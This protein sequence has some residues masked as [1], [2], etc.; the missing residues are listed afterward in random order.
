M[1]VQPGP[2]EKRY[3]ANGVTTI[4][5]VPFLV[6]EPGDLQVLLNGVLLS[7][8]YTHTGVGSPTSTITFAVAPTGDLLLQLSVPFQR[9]VDYQENGDFLSSTVNRDFDRVWQALKQL[10]RITSRSPVLGVNDID[11]QGQYQAKGNRLSN[12]ADPILAQDATTKIWVD[13]FVSGLLGAITGP[14]NNALNIFYRAPNGTSRVVQDIAVA[15]G[16]TLVGRGAGTLEDFLI[17]LAL[18]AELESTFEVGRADAPLDRVLDAT[19]YN[20]LNFCAAAAGKIR[21]IP[22]EATVAWKAN[23]EVGFFNDSDTALRISP[24]AGVSIVTP[25]G[26]VAKVTPRGR[27][28]IRRITANRWHI[29]GDLDNGKQ[30]GA[31]FA[32]G[33]SITFGVGSTPVGGVYVN[34]Y[35]RTLATYQ[36]RI[37]T[38]SA[39]AASMMYDQALVMFAFTIDSTFTTSL[40][41][42]T[43]DCRVYLD[44]AYRKDCFATAHLAC[45]SWL[46]VPDAYKVFPNNA[47]CTYT[48]SWG[49]SSYGKIFTKFTTT[50]GATVT[51]PFSGPVVYLNIMRTD[52]NATTGEV[53]IDGVLRSTVNFAGPG[54]GTLLSPSPAPAGA[55]GPSALRIGGLSDGPHSLELKIVTVGSGGSAT[56]LGISVPPPSGALPRVNAMTIIRSSDSSTDARVAAYNTL[57]ST[58]VAILKGDGLDVAISN[59]NAVIDPSTD[60]A[61]TLH[62]NDQGHNK[63]ARQAALDF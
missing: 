13:R 10:L 1:A 14:I 18:K 24:V 53:R 15:D 32:F 47:A 49:N 46:A 20:S 34:G 25:V 42:G 22:L 17:T 19:D 51:V 5:A 37:V 2:T 29:T 4:Y 30:Y 58:N 54:T 44:D 6:I 39:V 50:V 43:N 35:V 48:S 55:V 56:F 3:A 52:G 12:L 16:T 40:M 38:I 23:T 63:I 28:N 9:L 31:N 45:L 60:L 26:K 21:S 57:V 33:D 36:G 11:G 8:G 59:T 7:S 62:P 27:A 41:I 61:D